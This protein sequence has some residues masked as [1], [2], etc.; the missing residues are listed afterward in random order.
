MAALGKSKMIKEAFQTKV[1]HTLFQL[2]TKTD[3]KNLIKHT[4]ARHKN[5]YNHEELRKEPDVLNGRSFFLFLMSLSAGGEQYTR[6]HFEMVKS[7]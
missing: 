5:I 7:E 1:Y 3:F 6:L 4:L 2:C